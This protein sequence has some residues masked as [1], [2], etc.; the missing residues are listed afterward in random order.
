MSA[1]AKASQKLDH[2]GRGAS[3]LDALAERVGQHLAPQTPEAAL[4]PLPLLAAIRRAEAL[5]QPEI[6]AGSEL[7]PTEALGP[8]AQAAGDLAYGAQVSP[9][10]AGQSFLA[11][12]ALLAQ[13]RANVRTIDGGVRPLS[14]YCL[15]VARSGDGKDM[16]DRVALRAI[17]A[18]QQEAGQAWRREIQIYEENHASR[19]KN[20]A[21]PGAPPPAPYRLA[22]D[23]T[24]EGL[25][26]SYAEGVAGQGVFSTEAGIMLAGHAMNQDHRTKT[27]ASLCGLWDRGHLSVVRGGGGRLERYGVRLSAHLLAQ[28][29][30]LGDT[31]SDE[32]LS[33]IGFWPRF[34]LAWPDEL[35]PRVFRPWRPDESPAIGNFL[36]RCA[37]LLRDPMPDH[38]DDLL[39]IELS[40]DA[41]QELAAFFELMEHEARR[42][43]LRP[44]RA[45]ALRATEQACRIAGVMAAWTNEPMI[46]REAAQNAIRLVRYSL[47]SWRMA[48]DGKADPAPDW[49]LVLYR[50]LVTR[51]E[52]T[53]LRDIPRIGPV[54]LRSA[55]RRDAALDRL[56][57]AGLVA[58]G[59]DR[60]RALGVDQAKAQAA[61]ANAANPAKTRMDTGVGGHAN[62]CET[63]RMTARA[64]GE[65]ANIRSHSQAFAIAG[66]RMDTGDSHDSQLSQGGSPQTA[67]A[68]HDDKV[69]L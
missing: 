61:P 50:W 9:A 15:T 54:N 41:R 25:Q 66:T 20:A 31:L 1:I 57:A 8:L 69:A 36:A 38:C 43:E 42:G 3:I 48:L 34:L 30:A 56:L 35:A 21:K 29:E 11:A 7:Y 26:R 22:G 27:A 51:G 47:Q 4:E 18:F 63:L 55:S 33:G 10:M 62:G 60:V 65:L 58:V 52:P 59:T 19:S 2:A 64:D 40:A 24:I 23:I 6:D 5:L 16:A 46:D 45:F 13:S 53:L 14:L 12:A 68:P 49:A 17:H 37:E 44:V 39:V 28:P 67:I 32:S